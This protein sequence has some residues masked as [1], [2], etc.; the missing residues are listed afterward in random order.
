MIVYLYQSFNVHPIITTFLVF[1][2]VIILFIM[3][4]F[5]AE[6][7]SPILLLLL[8]FIIIGLL[9]W[10]AW[11]WLLIIGSVV[12]LGLGLFCLYGLVK[13]TIGENNNDI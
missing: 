13:K 9:F 12:V 6:L 2:G 8:P 7:L 1:L 4:R 3:A 10:F 11:T 5:V